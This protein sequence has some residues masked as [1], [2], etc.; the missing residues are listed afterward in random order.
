MLQKEAMMYF[1]YRKRGYSPY[2]SWFSAIHELSK[3]K[4]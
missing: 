4:S 3:N 2:L 1:S